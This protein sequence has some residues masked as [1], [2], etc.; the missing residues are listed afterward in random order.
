MSA[1]VDHPN[2]VKIFD[3]GVEDGIPYLVMEL[4][5]GRDLFDVLAEAGRLPAARAAAI[6]IQICDAVATA[7]D[8]GIVHR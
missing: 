2:A 7:H 6:A 1:Q 4:V 3:Q 5:E 8:R